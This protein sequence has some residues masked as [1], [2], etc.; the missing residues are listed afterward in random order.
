MYLLNALSLQF[1]Q[2]LFL[3]T[4]RFRSGQALVGTKDG[5]NVVFHTPGL[6]KYTHNLPFFDVSVYLNGLRLTLIDDYTV[7][8]SGGPGT[9]FDTVVLNEAPFS[10]DHLSADYLTT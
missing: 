8:E 4:N 6:E 10:D 5:T 9:G 7:A 3:A 2:Q 1:A